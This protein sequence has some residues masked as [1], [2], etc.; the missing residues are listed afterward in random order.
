MANKY[1]LIDAMVYKTLMKMVGWDDV[2]DRLEDI[3]AFATGHMDFPLSK[4]DV[5]A[6]LK[7]MLVKALRTIPLE[8]FL[9]D[10]GGVLLADLNKTLA[11]LQIDAT[12][13]DAATFRAVPWYTYSYAA[14]R[15]TEQVLLYHGFGQL[16]Y[17]DYW[18]GEAEDGQ[19]AP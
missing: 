8:E 18:C 11:E 2:E 9:A 15:A 14:L 13:S 16:L 5:E 6:S 4:E 12:V 7:R 1:G 17:E 10:H 3:H 19:D